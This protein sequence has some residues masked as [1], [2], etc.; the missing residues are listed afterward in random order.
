M[1]C[2]FA[3]AVTTYYSGVRD[4]ESHPRSIATQTECVMSGTRF[5]ATRSP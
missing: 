3:L 1:D 2:V 4:S 5:T